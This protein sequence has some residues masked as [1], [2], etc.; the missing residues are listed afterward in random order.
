MYVG[1]YGGNLDQALRVLKRK[2]AKDGILTEVRS[3]RS[4]M[5][6]GEKRKQK[7]NDAKARRLRKARKQKRQGQ[8]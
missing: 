6:K 7:D 8:R 5:S 2:V 4:A 1:V 3:R